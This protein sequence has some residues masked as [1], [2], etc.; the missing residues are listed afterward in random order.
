MKKFLILLL[1]IICCLSLSGCSFDKEKFKNNLND[2]FD[3]FDDEFG[4]L[5][6]E[7]EDNKNEEENNS[8]KLN[9]YEI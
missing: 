3:W 5:G 9:N 1:V 8:S 6:E 4:N 7:T 2:Y